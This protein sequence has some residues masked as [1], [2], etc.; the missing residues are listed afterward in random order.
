MYIRWFL[1]YNY[2]DIDM[3]HVVQFYKMSFTE[4][5]GKYDVDRS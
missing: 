2:K 5:P 4:Q 3:T 1:F